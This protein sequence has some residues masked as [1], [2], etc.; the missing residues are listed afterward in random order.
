[1]EDELVT[2]KSLV[3]GLGVS[4]FGILLQSYVNCEFTLSSCILLEGIFKI[5][6]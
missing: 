2:K 5:L 4:I 3:V 6:V 1:M